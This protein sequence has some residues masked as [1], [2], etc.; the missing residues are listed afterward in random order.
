MIYI[1]KDELSYKL[2]KYR[3]DIMG[4]KRSL[5]N[6]KDTYFNKHKNK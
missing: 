6:Q 4:E 2:N 3:T 1:K 5:I